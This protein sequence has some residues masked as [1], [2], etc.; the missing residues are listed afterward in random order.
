MGGDRETHVHKNFAKNALQ[1]LK[2]QFLTFVADFLQ[3]VTCGAFFKFQANSKF[4]FLL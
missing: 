1:D 2:I 4:G 3:R